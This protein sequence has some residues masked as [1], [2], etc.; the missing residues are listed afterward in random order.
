M[1]QSLR[2]LYRR[3]DRV[4]QH[5][6]FKLVASIVAVLLC[7]W[8]FGSLIYTSS[9]L[10][11]QRNALL[12]ALT[13]Q[14]LANN[15]IHA[16]SLAESGTVTL[17]NGKTYTAAFFYDNRDLI[18]DRRGA[19]SAPA[20]VA[21]DLLRQEYP[22]WA[23][24]WLLEHSGTAWM[25]A[26]VATGWLLLIIWLDLALALLLTVVGVGVPISIGLMLGGV[27]EEAGDW[28]V[29][30]WLLPWFL[31]NRPVQLFIGG[32]GLLSFTFALLTRAVGLALARPNQ[33]FSVA[34]NVV[35]EASRTRLSLLFILILLVMLPLIPLTLDHES[36]L[37]YQIQS[38]ISKSLGLTY[39][40]T[41]CLT[42]FL[43]CSTVAFEIRDRQ[44][45]Q[46]MTKPVHHFNYVLGKWLGV[47]MV[48][49]IIMIIASI[50]VFTYIQY[51]REQPVAAGL[52]GQ[53]DAALIR[54]A[55]L[56]ARIGVLPEFDRLSAE[57]LRARV[58]QRRDRELELAAIEDRSPVSD[59]ELRQQIQEDF[60]KSQ[61]SIPPRSELRPNPSQHA[62]EYIFDGLDEARGL[63]SNLS[64]RY[65]FHILRDDE[66]Q[67]FS[68]LFIINR[69]ET[70][71]I[72][73][74]YIPTVTHVLNIPAEWVREDGTLSVTIVNLYTAPP[75]SPD[76]GS[77]NFEMGGLELLYQVST[78]EANFLRAILIDWVKLA[79]LAMLGITC[80]TFLNF[81]V[82][83]L[84][85]FTIFIAGSIGPFLSASLL[86][87]DAPPASA[88]DWSNIG[89][90]IQWLFRNVIRGIAIFLVFALDTFGE[91]KPTQSLVEGRLVPWTTVLAA[92]L[93]LGLLW[94]G[95][96]FII[97]FL[98]MRKRQLAIYSGHG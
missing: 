19:V 10:Q 90:V 98:V 41:A 83:C 29:L 15:D 25:L 13:E 21:E 38:F 53:E 16:V 7:A 59:Y 11:S 61:R 9:S 82:A 40:I 88:I 14:S 27:E 4:Q 54:D 62:R 47:I 85:S 80:A 66:H 94:A 63:Q 89:I 36:P 51:L 79:F 93:K 18:F 73:R 23:P 6:R 58:E 31:A 49:L 12:D 33:L 8:I 22:D 39:A 74:T 26:G 78:F 43:A 28:P 76:Y 32:V 24:R 37:R 97:G 87:Y 46:L 60:L 95:S 67:T 42:L 70:K 55:V 69:D 1:I 57:E 34:H 30:S 56:T 45:W 17:E 48:N 50:S 44:I 75:G 35:R 52:A 91:F 72:E 64:L 77:I 96:A 20:L 5:P 3:I 92:W 68:A 84:M 81:P 86:E 71:V 65:R 2:G